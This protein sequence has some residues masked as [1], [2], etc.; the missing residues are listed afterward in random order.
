MTVWVLFK[1]LQVR[2]AAKSME[3]RTQANS[4]KKLTLGTITSSARLHSQIAKC[5]IVNALLHHR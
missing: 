3:R 1:S 2:L 5:S 4:L